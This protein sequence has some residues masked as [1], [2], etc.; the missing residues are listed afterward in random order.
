MSVADAIVSQGLDKLGY[1]VRD[2][3]SFGPCAAA[4]ALFSASL[5]A[6]PLLCSELCGSLL[7][8]TACSV[9]Q[10]PP[11]SH[12][13]RYHPSRDPAPPPAPLV[14]VSFPPVSPVRSTSSWTTYVCIPPSD[15]ARVWNGSANTHTH[16]PHSLVLCERRACVRACVCSAG[17][18]PPGT[19]RAVCNPK[20]HSSPP[21]SPP[22]RVRLRAPPATHPRSHTHFGQ[23]AVDG[24][25]PNYG[26]VCDRLPHLCRPSP[27]AVVC[28]LPP[29]PPPHPHPPAPT[30]PSPAPR[31][32][33]LQGPAHRPVHV[34]R[35]PHLPRQ[36]PG[37]LWQLRAGRRH[38]RQLGVRLCENRQLQQAEVGVW[39]VTSLPFP[40]AE[41]F[42]RHS[43]P[44]EPRRQGADSRK[45]MPCRSVFFLACAVLC[46]R[47]NYTEEQLYVWWSGK[48]CPPTP[49]PIAM[50]D[51]LSCPHTHLSTD[52][53]AP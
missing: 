32:R 10:Y 15:R 14:R 2:A 12:T 37:F 3:L 48:A 19:R 44:A 51:C 7:P 5:P 31:V 25:R 36:P 23:S 52:T 13:H 49:S 50:P 16:T 28:V 24:P 22:S 29:P 30:H 40:A 26:C 34:H 39:R 35:H 17:P 42:L 33:S 1:K 20:R 53:C 8:A 6:S 43:S 11:S 21:A 38:H 27:H 9:S 47:S 46:M 4:P 45:L 18:P 41:F